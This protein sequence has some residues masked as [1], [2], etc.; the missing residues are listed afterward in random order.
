MN[1]YSGLLQQIGLNPL[2]EGIYFAL[3]EN[4]TCSIVELARILKA[5]RPVIYKELPVLLDYKLVTKSTK[6][7]RVVY[8]AASP[9][10]IATLAKQRLDLLESSLPE[11]LDTFNN[12]DKRPGVTVLEGKGGI[13]KAFERLII[14]TEK[15]GIIYRY[16]SPD[17]YKRYKEYYPELYLKRAGSMGDIDKFT[18]T[19]TA[20]HQRRHNNLNRVSKQVPVPFEYNITQ[21]IGNDVVV[22][23]D[24]NTE[25]AMMIENARF[26]DFQRSIFK[27]L[28]EKL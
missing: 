21:L 10:V 22:F 16:E 13:A 5:H 24:F 26:A 28:F 19:N 2:A 25:T 6:G 11:L 18:I 23:I 8:E 27:I 9:A 4:G 12:R 1:N 17:D 7:K 20:T 15:E 3:L 14:A